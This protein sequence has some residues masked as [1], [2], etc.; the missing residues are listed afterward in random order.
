M[1]SGK[2]PVET[3]LAGKP[4]PETGQK[5]FGRW[6]T[7]ILA[8]GNGNWPVKQQI[9]R[10]KCKFLPPKFEK[11]IFRQFWAVDDPAGPGRP[12]RPGQGLAQWSQINQKAWKLIQSGSQQGVS[13]ISRANIDLKGSRN[14]MEPLSTPKNQIKKPK[15]MIV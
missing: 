12:A 8:G 3:E 2:R 6:K 1:A 9:G 11:P 13:Y 14:V 15:S 10:W 7:M 4:L 5:T